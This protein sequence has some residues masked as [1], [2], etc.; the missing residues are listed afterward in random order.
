MLNRQHNF[1]V[2]FALALVGLSTGCSSQGLKNGDLNAIQ[3]HSTAPRAGNVYLERGLIGVFS[4]GMDVLAEQL[5][6][7]GMRC[8]V[9]QDAQH[10]VLGN[11]LVK[12][13]RGKTNEREPLVLIG[14]SYGADD[15]VGIC[16]KLDAANI[17]VDLLVTVDA[18]TPPNVPKNVK[19]VYNYYQSTATDFIP[20]F[21]GIPLTPDKDAKNVKIVN[22]DLRKQRTDLL[23][24]GT[25]H[26]NIDKNMKLHK[27]LVD[28]VLEVCPPRQTWLAGR[29]NPTT[30]PTMGTANA[31]T[32][33]PATPTARQTQAA[34]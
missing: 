12:V 13:Y 25:N 11:Q 1:V 6:D 34:Q 8:H 5:R 24:P 17:P 10:D 7:Q 26:I 15:V 33:L 19:M 31:A 22:I 30:R 29:G 9:Y 27:V 3:I 14:H 20:M 28:H 32:R 16:R 23:E 21:R 18:T 4:T 2:L